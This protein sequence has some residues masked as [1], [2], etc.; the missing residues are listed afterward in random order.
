[1]A[2]ASRRKAPFSPVQVDYVLTHGQVRLFRLIFSHDGI[3]SA[4]YCKFTENC[5]Y[6]IPTPP[7]RGRLLIKLTVVLYRMLTILVHRTIVGL[8]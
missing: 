6:S 3:L 7:F 5:G 1:M 2:P 4:I 8:F